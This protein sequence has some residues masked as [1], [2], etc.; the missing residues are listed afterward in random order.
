M[1]SLRILVI[2]A[3]GFLARHTVPLLAA[4]PGAEVITLGRGTGPEKGETRHHAVDCGELEAI[5][6]V[7]DT[8]SPDRILNLAGSS[9]PDFGEMLRYNVQISEAVLAAAAR[10]EKSAPVRVILTGSAAEFGNPNVLPVTENCPASPCNAYGLTKAMQTELAFYFRRTQSEK[11]RVTVAHLFN[12]I[13]PGCPDRLAFGSFVRQIA[14]MGGEG[15]LQTGN[16]ASQRDFIHVADA[17]AALVALSSLA[18]PGPNYVIATGRAVSVQTLLD[19]LIRVSKRRIEVEVAPSRLSACDVP[20]VFGSSERMS[21]DT[22]WHPALTAESAI[23][24]MWRE[25]SG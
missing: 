25:I 10:L 11:L 21:N 15:T 2:G 12:L 23:E 14:G 22:G 9:G 13:G 16:L 7:I 19:H 5:G 24:E 4:Q 3:G 1:M 8:E 18:D 17:A 20:V 6:R